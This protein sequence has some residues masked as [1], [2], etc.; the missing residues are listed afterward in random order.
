MAGNKIGKLFQVTTWGES[1]GK[2]VGVVIDGCP[3]RIPLNEHRIQT[4]LNR[5]RPGASMASTQRREKD[6]AVIF[7]GVFEGLTTGTPIMIMVEN[8]D[9]NSNAYKPYA[10]V[11]RPGH[12]DY[13]YQAKYGIRDRRGKP[14]P[15]WLPVQWRKHYW[16]G[17]ESVSR[18]TPSNWVG[19]GRSSAIWTLRIKTH[20]FVRTCKLLMP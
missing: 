8:K 7:S 16:T 3:P 15:G 4:L 14:W 1:H 10:D 2:A 19:S 18:L 11:Y 17:S 12:G 6:I 13:T 20:F 9:A 5:R